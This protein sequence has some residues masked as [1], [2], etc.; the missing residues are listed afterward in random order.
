MQE[1]DGMVREAMWDCKKR[2]RS[3][4]TAAPIVEMSGKV[5]A[6]KIGTEGVSPGKLLSSDITKLKKTEK[7]VAWRTD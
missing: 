7:K 2:M 3:G 5:L 1:V 4:L 6:V